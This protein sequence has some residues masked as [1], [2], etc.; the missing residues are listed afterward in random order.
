MGKD[1]YLHFINK[2]INCILAEGCCCCLQ[3]VKSLHSG[4]MLLLLQNVGSVSGS[5]Q[6][7][8]SEEDITRFFSHS[9]LIDQNC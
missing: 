2:H 5:G 7:N 8:G 6:K 9:I 3:M 4:L 1:I